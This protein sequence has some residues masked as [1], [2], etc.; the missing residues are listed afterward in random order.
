MKQM[1][2]WTTLV[3][4]CLGLVL[5]EMASAQAM[6]SLTG[7]WD[8]DVMKSDDAEEAIREGLGET[9][10]RGS[11]AV[12][13]QRLMERLI[14][15]ARAADYMELE[16]SDQD[17]KVFDRADRVSIYYLDGKKHERQGPMGDKMEAI[18][19]WD[20]SRVTVTTEGKEIGRILEIYGLEGH[21]MAYIVSIENKAFEQEVVIR[22]YYNRIDGE[23]R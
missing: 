2:R 8:L 5:P 15:L 20:G 1:S 7:K 10:G 18:A 16:L 17:L 11:R 6:P 12:Q 13:R 21:Q 19:D 23:N 3:A 4:V 22:H 9:A 14:P